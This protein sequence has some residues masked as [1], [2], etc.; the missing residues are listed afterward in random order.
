MKWILPPLSEV[1]D[2]LELCAGS[3]ATLVAKVAPDDVEQAHCLLFEILKELQKPENA[4]QSKA[5]EAACSVGLKVKMRMGTDRMLA[6]FQTDGSTRSSKII[7]R[8]AENS[9]PETF[10]RN[11]DDSD[12]K[13]D[14]FGA[15]MARINSE[16]QDRVRSTV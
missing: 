12:E 9:L 10:L 2:H 3:P 13:P 16:R 6:H 15:Y 8:L 11:E 4:A 7:Q 14:E 5:W 1:V